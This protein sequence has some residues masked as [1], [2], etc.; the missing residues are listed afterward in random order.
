MALFDGIVEFVALAESQG[1]TAAG[2]QLGVSTSHISRRVS[3]LEARL[4]TALVARSTR[5][6]RLTVAGQNYYERCRDLVHGLDEANLAISAANVEVS[7][8]LR[9]SAAGEFA[10]NIA[11]PVLIEFL[12]QYPSLNID[13]DF[14]SRV[15]NFVEEGIDF[16]IR[17][18]RLNDS[19]LI[20]RKLV[21]RQLVAVASPGYLQQHGTSKHPAELDRHD[22]IIAASERWQFTVDDK[23]FDMKVR[24]RWR[25][26]SGR[27][28]VR[29]CRAG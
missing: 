29:A 17:Y 3:D 27:S 6:V 22:C 21:D 2:R 13:I 8:T 16:A 10:E 26:N 24:G 11:V 20:A 4:C 23:S 9:V 15:V 14:N 7:G 5:T 25:S 19:G 28:L 1:F 12:H 18:G